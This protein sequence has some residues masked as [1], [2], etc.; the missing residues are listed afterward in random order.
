M[1]ELLAGDRLKALSPIELLKLHSAAADELKSR[2]LIRSANN[3]VGDLAEGL[4]C[5]AFGWDMAPASMPASDAVDENGKRYQ[6][7]SRRLA[8]RTSS[9]QLSAIRNLGG[10]GFDVLAAVLFNADYGVFRAALIPHDVVVMK[11]RHQDHTNSAIFIL[12]DAIWDIRGVID[13]TPRLR[14]ACDA[15]HGSTP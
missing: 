1:K 4:F 15:W 14:T 5:R 6:I 10:K 11:S 8:T 12:N 9:R 2:G 7:K 3:P 13:V